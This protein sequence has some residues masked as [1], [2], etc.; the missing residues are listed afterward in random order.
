MSAPPRPPKLLD[1]VR[2]ACRVRHYSIRT[3]DAYHDWVRR[4]VLFHDLR[5]PDTMA[6]PEVNAFLT[7]LAVNG[8]VAASTQNQA[9]SALLFLYEHVLGRPLDRIG[10]VVRAHKPKR[11]PVVMSR[12]EVRRVLAG[13]D[14][15]HRLV[16]QL[17]YGAGL[18]LL[19]CLRLRVKDEEWDL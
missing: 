8:N 18:R 12:D 15:T 11:L 3:E 4:F 1:R 10:G 9:L 5:H 16:G 7:D 17:M 6:E 14:D 19:E 13:L 2:H